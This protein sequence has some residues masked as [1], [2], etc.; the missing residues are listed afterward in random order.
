MVQAA[1]LA[2][3]KNTP[4]G[5]EKDDLLLVGLEKQGKRKLGLVGRLSPQLMKVCVHLAA[6]VLDENVNVQ[7]PPPA[8]LLKQHHL[9]VKH[10]PFR[11]SRRRQKPQIQAT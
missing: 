7:Q 6:M 11:Y 3:P 2:D 4:E 1:L 5:I 9:Q 10:Y 8:L